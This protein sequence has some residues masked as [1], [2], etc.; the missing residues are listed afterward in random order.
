MRERGRRDRERVV[1][2]IERG[3]VKR[4][5]RMRGRRDRERKRESGRGDKEREREIDP[6]LSAMHRLSS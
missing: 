4:R 3:A 2:E 6:L 5:M 1:G